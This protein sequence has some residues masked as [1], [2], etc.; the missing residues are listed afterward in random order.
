MDMSKC[1]VDGCDD[2]AHAKGYCR[3]HYN[4][5]WRHGTLD[6]KVKTPKQ[7]SARAMQDSLTALE[8]D[9]R[10]VNAVY[11]NAYGEARFTWGQKKREL[12][13]QLALLKEQE[14][15]RHKERVEV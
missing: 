15:N 9:L 6:P 11:E 10:E 5:L 12:E 2:L 1:S 7:R 4:R 8:A 13:H 14:N 3:T